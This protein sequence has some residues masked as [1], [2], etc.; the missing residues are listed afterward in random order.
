MFPLGTSSIDELG[1]F[2]MDSWHLIVLN[3]QSLIEKGVDQG[4]LVTIAKF[5]T[6]FPFPNLRLRLSILPK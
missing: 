1:T 4:N 3:Q 2:A 5:V 6:V